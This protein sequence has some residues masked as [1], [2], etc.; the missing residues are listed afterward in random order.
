MA[1]SVTTEPTGKGVDTTTIG[2]TGGASLAGAV[3][4]VLV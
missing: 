3:A 1:A 4:V 2:A